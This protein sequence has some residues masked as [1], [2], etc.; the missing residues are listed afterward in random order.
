M[1]IWDELIT[2]DTHVTAVCKSGDWA[3]EGLGKD[4]VHVVVQNANDHFERCHHSVDIELELGFGEPD[5][6]G[7]GRA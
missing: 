6:T 4:R 5:E 7:E 3:E 2:D 1:G